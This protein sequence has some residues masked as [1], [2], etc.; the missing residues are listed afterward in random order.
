MPNPF[1]NDVKIEFNRVVSGIIM[2]SDVLGNIIYKDEIVSTN[3]IEINASKIKM[4]SGM[5][6]FRV[7]DNSGKI[8]KAALMK[9]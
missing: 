1:V 6:F 7:E 9:E 5:Y 8:Y 3:S 2:I 4:S